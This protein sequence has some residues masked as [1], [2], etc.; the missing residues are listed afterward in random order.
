MLSLVAGARF[1]YFPSGSGYQLVGS[2]FGL[3]G[4][5]ATFDYV[6]SDVEGYSRVKLTKYEIIGGGTAGLT[7]ANRLS[8]AG[9]SVAVIEAGSFYEISNSNLSQIPAYAQAPDYQPLVDWSLVAEPQ[10][11]RVARHSGWTSSATYY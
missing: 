10:P 7:V 2:S 6:V 11:V 8:A 9:S 5:N 3:P 4:T 1:G